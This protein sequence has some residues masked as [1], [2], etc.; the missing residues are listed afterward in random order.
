MALP[1]GPASG[2]ARE[3]ADGPRRAR[4]P[5]RGHQGGEDRLCRR[6][7]AAWSRGLK[8]G[9][10]VK[11]KFLR[12][13][14]ERQVGADRWRGIKLVMRRAIGANEEI[15]VLATIRLSALVSESIPS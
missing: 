2:H 10:K 5:D 11:I 1:I 6:L 4:R 8:P 3:L 15:N 13:D 14:T 12:D 9:E 7:R